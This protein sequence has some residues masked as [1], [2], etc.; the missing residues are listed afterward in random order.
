[1]SRCDEKLQKVGVRQQ[2]G[3]RYMMVKDRMSLF[4]EA[5]GLEYGVCTKI[6]HSDEKTVVVHAKILDSDNRVLGSGLAEEQRGGTHVNKG[7]AL[8]NCESSAIGRALASIGLH[9]GEYPTFDELESD[10][11]SRK[12][13]DERDA[14]EAKKEKPPA[15]PTPDVPMP[16]IVAE[17]IPFDPGEAK[18]DWPTWVK[19]IG[20]LIDGSRDSTALMATWTAAK[21]ERHKLR[22]KHPELHAKLAEGAK[23]RRAVLENKSE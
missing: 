4:R 19:K 16:R 9:G 23:K 10:K 7:S 11:R 20:E 6:L 17:E 21:P 12:V 18:K 1:M 22:E 3:K 5:Y 8:E 2:G 13:L 15:E 14:E